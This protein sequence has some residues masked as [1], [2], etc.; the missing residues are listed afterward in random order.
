VEQGGDAGE[1][2][3]TGGQ[4]DGG[5]PGGAQAGGEGA[6]KEVA[7]AGEASAH[8]FQAI[9]GHGESYAGGG[10]GKGA[11]AEIR[12]GRSGDGFALGFGGGSA[13]PQFAGGVAVEQVV[14]LG[15]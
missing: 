2:V 12:P 15:G 4:T 9:V 1:W 5:E 7:V 11:A 8:R 3:G 6:E 14:H 13:P 10:Q